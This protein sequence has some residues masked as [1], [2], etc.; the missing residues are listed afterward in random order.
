MKILRV[1]IGILR[2]ADARARSLR[3]LLTLGA[4]AQRGLVCLS[5]CVCVCVCVCVSTLILKLQATRPPIS[6][7]SGFSTT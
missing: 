6:D 7:T 4:H 3:Q 1:R 2:G 5:V